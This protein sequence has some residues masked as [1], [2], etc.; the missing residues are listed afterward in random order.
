MSL[1]P[2]TTS[3]LRSNHIHSTV[4]RTQYDIRSTFQNKM[5]TKTLQAL[6]AVF[7]LLR[8]IKP[9]II[10]CY[11]H[12]FVLTRK[13]ILLKI[14]ICK[15]SPRKKEIYYVRRD[16]FFY[17]ILFKVQTR[18]SS[19][20]KQT[21]HHF[22]PEHMNIIKRS[23]QIGKIQTSVLQSLDKHNRISYWSSYVY[24]T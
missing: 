5:I 18:I 7:A 2:S 17:C 13:S 14:C 22:F 9:I 23:S 20:V 4:G 16:F 1:F 3:L 12:T 24:G 6:P 8:T 11:T 21:L 15:I 19:I 10:P